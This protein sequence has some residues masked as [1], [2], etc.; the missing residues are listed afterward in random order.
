[1]S[2]GY[3]YDIYLRC[4]LFLNMESNDNGWTIRK[5]MIL[6]RSRLKF[7]IYFRFIPVEIAL[8]L[9]FREYMSRSSFKHNN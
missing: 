2:Y 1:M 6:E 5:K 7:R 4:S 8:N 3:R 9:S